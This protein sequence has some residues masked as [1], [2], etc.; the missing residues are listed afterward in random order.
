MPGDKERLDNVN[1][2]AP[3]PFK[4][5]HD[6]RDNNWHVSKIFWGLLFVLIGG[7]VLASNFGW[8]EVK[9]FNLWR[10]WPLIIVAIGL[11]ILAVHNLVWRIFT[12]VFAVST[13]V[14]ITWVALGNYSRLPSFEKDIQIDKNG[15]HILIKD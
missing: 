5:K 10:L 8:A 2:V 15:V 14:F 6:K 3:E 1:A 7:L 12:V 13:L 11:S 9:W 4:S